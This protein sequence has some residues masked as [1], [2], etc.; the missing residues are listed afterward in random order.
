M[1]HSSQIGKEPL[2]QWKLYEQGDFYH[3]VSDP[4]EKNPVPIDQLTAQQKQLKKKFQGVLS[5]MKR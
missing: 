5:R 4:E 3:F 2:S 1:S